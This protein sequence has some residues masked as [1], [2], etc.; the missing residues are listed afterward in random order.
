MVTQE[1]IETA[2]TVTSIIPFSTSNSDYNSTAI[3]TQNNQPE[4]IPSELISLDI[5]NTL[6][7]A[8]N[9]AKSRS[10]LQSLQQLP[11]G[12]RHNYDRSLSATEGQG[13][14][15]DSQID[16]LCHS[17]ADNTFLPLNKAYTTTS[18]LSGHLKRQPEGIKQCIA[19]QRVPDPFRSVE[20]LHQFLPDCEKFSGPSQHLQVAQWMA[21]I[22]RKEIHD[23]FN[24]RMEEK[25]PSNH[26]QQLQ[27]EK[28]ATS[29]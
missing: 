4:S 5:I 24:I 22:Y 1:N 8:K 26:Q 20:K 17:E 15:N 16:K 29:F 28:V 19:A 7:K 23:A 9:L 18:I 13:S 11:K 21:F 14:V 25:Q 10:Q 6:Q 12:K 3:I 27:R 2:S